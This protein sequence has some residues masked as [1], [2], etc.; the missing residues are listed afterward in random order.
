LTSIFILLAALICAGLGFCPECAPRS[1]TAGVVPT[2]QQRLRVSRAVRWHRCLRTSVT[3]RFPLHR[4]GIGGLSEILRPAPAPVLP[5]LP[6][7]L[8][9]VY[10]VFGIVFN[11]PRGRSR[12]LPCDDISHD[13]SPCFVLCTQ[14]APAVIFLPCLS[15]RAGLCSIR[16]VSVPTTE[17][18]L[19]VIWLAPLGFSVQLRFSFAPS[20]D[21]R[22]SVLLEFFVFGPGLV[23]SQ[24]CDPCYV[25]D[26]CR[27][28]SVFVLASKRLE[29]F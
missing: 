5:S 18:S 20:F 16:L 28:K 17:F 24:S 25:S 29:F 1:H 15:S 22:S 27:C 12:F 13:S 9:P 10:S 7:L 3:S 8:L 6:C 19:L 21:F 11:G 23:L 2:S 4:P 26:Y 14:I